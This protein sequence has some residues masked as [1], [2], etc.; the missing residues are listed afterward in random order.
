LCNT[1]RSCTH[2]TSVSYSYSG[3]YEGALAKPMVPVVVHDCSTAS[4]QAIITATTSTTAA[5]AAAVMV[6]VDCNQAVAAGVS[7]SSAEH[8]HISNK[9]HNNSGCSVQHIID[10]AHAAGAAAATVIL[11]SDVTA[12]AGNNLLLSMAKLLASLKLLSAMLP[13]CYYH[14]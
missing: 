6:I 4:Q 1:Y 12:L 13:A 14:I 8:T 5:A 9:Q 10:M 2:A 3:V 7:S 11:V